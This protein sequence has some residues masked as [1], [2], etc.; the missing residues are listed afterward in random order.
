MPVLRAALA[1]VLV[2]LPRRKNVIAPSMAALRPHTHPITFQAGFFTSLR[3]LFL[4]LT[5]F[6]QVSLERLVDRVRG[7]DTIERRAHRIRVALERVGGTFVKFGQQVAMRIDVVPWEYC[8]ELSKMLDRMPPFPVEAALAAVERAAGKPWTE[9]F[10]V[11]DPQPVGSASLACV[12]QAVLKDG[13]KVAVKVRR[14]GIGRVFAADFRVLDWLFNVVEALA[15]IR[16]GFT[17]D[18]RREF[19]ETLLEELD[20]RKEAQ[21]QHIFRRRAPTEKG[22]DFFTAP[23]VYDTL[24]SGDVIVQEFVSGMFLWEVIAAVEHRD[25]E[26]LAMMERLDIDPAVVARRILWSA[27]WSFEENLFFHAD[28]HPANII[29]GEHSTLTFIDFGSC[30]SFNNEQRW[31]MQ[32]IARAMRAGDAEGMARATLKMMEPFPPIDVTGVM[33]EVQEEYTRVLYTFRTKAEHTQWWERTSARQWLSMVKVAHKYNLPFNL[34]TLRVIR[35]TLLYDTVVIRLDHSLDRYK[36]YGEFLRDQ[37]K[38]ARNR[39][40]RRQKNNRLQF[41]LRA[42]DLAATAGDMLERAQQTL[43]SPVAEFTSMIDKSVFAFSVLTRLA[44]RLL[45]LAAAGMAVIGWR[46]YHLTGAVDLG[47]LFLTVVRGKPYGVIAIALIA[48]NARHILFRFRERD[49]RRGRNG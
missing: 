20:F 31:A 48:V 11:F 3:R 33:K 8:V 40:R 44:G 7:R 2:P 41:A 27:F 34:H 39:W 4:W 24:C 46:A 18:L 49:E 15:I 16:P 42:S 25:P 22:Q 1:D 45:F 47:A 36:E 30:G 14:P 26:G 6:G 38:W 5:V 28:P 9:I 19:R 13:S 35:A 12:F 10:A 32:R 43:S 23:K 17:H 21:F 37:A 29:V